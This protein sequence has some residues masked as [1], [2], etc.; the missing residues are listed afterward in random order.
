MP[1][2]NLMWPRSG[3]A[4]ASM[5]CSRIQDQGTS[6]SWRGTDYCFSKFYRTLDNTLQGNYFYVPYREIAWTTQYLSSI[7]CQKGPEQSP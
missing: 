7:P 6:P 2:D 3:V 1:R 4:S 5:K